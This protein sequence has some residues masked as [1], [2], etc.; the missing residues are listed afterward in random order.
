MIG[1]E[2]L[3]HDDMGA[4][5]QTW[6]S[7]VDE[8]D[9][10]A[11][12]SKEVLLIPV[13]VV[14]EATKCFRTGAQGV[15]PYLE[16]D[17]RAQQVVYNRVAH[18]LARRLRPGGGPATDQSRPIQVFLS[19]A[20]A[21]GLEVVQLLQQ[22]FALHEPMCTF[23]DHVDL[24]AGS[25][26]RADLGEAAGRDVL[27]V[28]WTDQYSSRT[29]CR[30]ELM[31][32][33]RAEIAVIVV[34]AGASFE[35]WSFPLLGNC[36]VVRWTGPATCGT[37][38]EVAVREA[39]RV[40]HARRS[41]EAHAAARERVFAH[42]PDAWSLLCARRHPTRPLED[43]MTVLY[44]DPPLGPDVLKELRTN[45]PAIQLVSPS[46]RVPSPT[47]LLRVALSVSET[48]D[49]QVFGITGPDV[50][51]VAAEVTRA[52]L[53]Q[54]HT[55]IYGGSLTYPG[56]NDENAVTRLL[57]MVQW[58]ADQDDEPTPI[59]NVVPWPLSAKLPAKQ[60]SPYV[61][62]AK[63][64]L[65]AE[66]AGVPHF[67]TEENEGPRFWKP[68]TPNWRQAWTLG[69]TAMRRKVIEQSE[70]RISLGGKLDGFAGG[71]PGVAEEILLSIAE[72]QPTFLLGGFGGATRAVA[73]RLLGRHRQEFDNAWQD[74]DTAVAAWRSAFNS[75]AAGWEAHM[76][77]LDAK[78]GR[79]LDE[80]LRNGLS[81]EQNLELVSTQRVE[82]IVSLLFE[83]LRNLTV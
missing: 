55:V 38:A 74:R 32:A 33:R 5:L 35:P 20:K 27:V 75:T 22:H 81:H 13:A 24:A 4:D 68:A 60:R 8:V 1:L 2:T 15:R 51:A 49:A 80:T 59:L 19:H 31:A 12:G 72:G 64:D 78:A 58:L 11:T 7:F 43:G 40:T 71:W 83:G 79:P 56:E 25:N 34:G 70:A 53:H 36:P 61:G 57:A 17:G 23:Y 30:R 50:Q 69:L 67:D 3:E 47:K 76:A 52:L 65:L 42:R 66:P 16:V 77:V 54:G 28:L 41:L 46:T 14:R 63:F 21:D 82:R 37:I 29:W 62:L 6:S 10:L 18:E 45:F 9:G 48:R 26:W 39:L 44:P 73:D